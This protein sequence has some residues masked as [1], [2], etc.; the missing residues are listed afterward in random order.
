MIKIFFSLIFVFAFLG[1]EKA[2]VNI[3]NDALDALPKTLVKHDKSETALNNSFFS[4]SL[5]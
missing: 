1:C 4:A 2:D 5:S 3:S